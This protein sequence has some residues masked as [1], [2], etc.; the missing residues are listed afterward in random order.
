MSDTI[1]KSALSCLLLLG[2]L[3]LFPVM[4]SAKL[5]IETEVVS[6]IISE[7][8]D[9]QAVRLN[10]GMIYQPSREGF[11][12][13]VQVGEPITLRCVVEDSKKNVYIEFAPGLHSLKGQKPA[14]SN[15]D[16][17]PK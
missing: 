2:L 16:L 1:G 14:S 10:N 8:F 12:V 17:T 11:V 5:M 3:Y 9:N 7:K 4:S 6:G 13:D 15:K